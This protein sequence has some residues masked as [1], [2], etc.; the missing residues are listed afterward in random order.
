M[1]AASQQG[2]I[3]L[4]AAASSVFFLLVNESL[5]IKQS[6][7]CPDTIVRASVG[8]DSRV[9]RLACVLGALAL[10]VKLRHMQQ[11]ADVVSRISASQVP[12]SRSGPKLS[13]QR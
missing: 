6:R 11:C 1:T 10:R 9:T 2:S 3:L 8:Q 4:H 13:S 12:V 7:V 5:F